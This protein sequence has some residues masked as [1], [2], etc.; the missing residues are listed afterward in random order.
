VSVRVVSQKVCVLAA[1][2]MIML[3]PS[4]QLL[5]GEVHKSKAAAAGSVQPIN[6]FHIFSACPPAVCSASWDGQND[7]AGGYTDF[8]PAGIPEQFS[9]T[10]GNPVDWYCD[11]QTEHCHADYNSGTFTATGPAGTFTG[12][13]TSGYA[14]EQAQGYEILVSFTGQWS[15]GQHM[16]GTADEHYSEAFQ[17]PDTTLA[18]TPMH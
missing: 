9:F 8:T 12:V 14:D 3:G 18:L 2:I 5:R 13:I 11:Q 6:P 16:T 4:V 10:T 7:S 1:G 15:N 17:V